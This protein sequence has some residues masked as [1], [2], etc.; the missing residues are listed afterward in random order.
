LESFDLSQSCDQ[1]IS[2]NIEEDGCDCAVDARILES[3][4]SAELTGRRF[5]SET[6]LSFRLTVALTKA[7][8]VRYITDDFPAVLTAQVD[9]IAWLYID[10]IS[11]KINMADRGSW[12]ILMR[13]MLHLT[14]FYVHFGRVKHTGMV[15]QMYVLCISDVSKFSK[16]VFCA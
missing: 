3:I 14:L 9:S 12:S 13:L 10:E 2:F 16:F 6:L 8:V 5:L 11:G 1:S 4:R 15:L 7:V